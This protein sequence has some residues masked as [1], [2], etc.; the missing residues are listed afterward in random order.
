MKLKLSFWL[1]TLL[2]LALVAGVAILVSDRL[3]PTVSVAEARIGTAV[4][5][6][7]GTVRVTAQIDLSV[8]TEVDGRLRDLKVQLGQ[9]VKQGEVVAEMESEEIALQLRQQRIR[10]EAARELQELPPT[11]KHDL[12]QALAELETARV[13]FQR[14]AVSEADLR[15]RMREVEKL[16]AAVRSEEIRRREAADLLMVGVQILEHQVA[17]MTL[18]APHDGEVL[19]VKA[20][21][22]SWLWRGNQIVR[23]SSEERSIE[24]TLSEEDSHGVGLGQEATV[25]LASFPGDPIRAVVEYLF[26]VADSEAKTRV[27]ALRVE[28]GD[29]RL[30]PGLTGEAVLMKDTRPNAVLIPRRA[31]MG[32]RVY[33]VQDEVVQVREVRSGFLALNFAEILSGLEA[34]EMVVLENQADLR[35]GQRVRL[36]PRAGGIGPDRNPRS[37]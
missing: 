18:R 21:P 15:R 4:N 14:G 29:P 17:R 25:R 26:P 13:A 16:E 27:V 36:A 32:N 22:G 34:G 19:E 20:F 8:S 10:L 31:L 9:R 11:S 33:V 30:V 7:T 2:P 24:L 28:G 12:E 6:V 5:A 35:A 37:R 23:L 3:R 1:K